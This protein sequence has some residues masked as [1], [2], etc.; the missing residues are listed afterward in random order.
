[1][2]EEQGE[3]EAAAGAMA[4]AQGIVSQLLVTNHEILAGNG[5]RQGL[6]H[7]GFF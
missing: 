5:L 1:L 6:V 4:S 2:A 3:P 7:R